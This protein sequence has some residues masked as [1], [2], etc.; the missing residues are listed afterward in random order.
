MITNITPEAIQAIHTLANRLEQFS[1]DMNRCSLLLLDTFHD[2]KEGLGNHSENILTNLQNLT[3]ALL[4]NIQKRIKLLRQNANNRNSIISSNFYSEPN[5]SNHDP[6]DYLYGVI[7][8]IYE[9]SYRA[10]RKPN[11][12]KDGSTNVY[13]PDLNKKPTVYNPDNKTFGQIIQDLEKK[14]NICYTGTPFIH[15]FADFSQIALAKIDLDEIIEMHS[16]DFASDADTT[17]WSDIFSDRTHNLHY[18][19]VIASQK[20]L[21]IP[22]LHE[23]YTAA[24]LLKWRTTNHFTWDE[25]YLNGYLL[26]PSEIHNN[27]PHTGLV[28]INKHSK[29]NINQ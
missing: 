5:T 17:N 6:A 23:N 26:V 19:D 28:A 7:S 10:L 11:S 27:I 4:P 8:R 3:C 13:M 15:S 21:Y 22:E 2:N 14:F 1:D 16:K 25:S 24:E 29:K 12:L 20:K 18:A 9:S